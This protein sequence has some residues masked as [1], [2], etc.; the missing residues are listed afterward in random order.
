MIL[1]DEQIE[2][3][4]G[5]FPCCPNPSTRTTQ[6]HALCENVSNAVRVYYESIR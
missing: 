3:L 2:E 4:K 1:T 5:M 6:V